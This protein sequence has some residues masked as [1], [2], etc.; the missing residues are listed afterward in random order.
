[1]P[2]R[3]P[4]RRCGIHRARR[5][6]GSRSPR[7]D[8]CEARRRTGPGAALRTQHRLRVPRPLR[9]SLRRPTGRASRADQAAARALRAG[10]PRR[11]RAR[12]LLARHGAEDRPDPRHSARS[13]LD[14]LRRADGWPRSRRRGGYAPLPRRATRPRRRAHR[15]NA[16]PGRGRAHRGQDRDHASRCN[17]QVRN[18]RRAPARVTRGQAIHSQAR[19]GTWRSPG[20]RRVARR[21]HPAP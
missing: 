9:L 13:R 2:G 21:K 14:L 4:S 12:G 20:A 6:A 17:R 15:D 10:R 5:A 7:R 16:R 18:P 3:N 19:G 11:H 1:M 8:S